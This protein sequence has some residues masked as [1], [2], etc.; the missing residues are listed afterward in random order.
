MQALLLLTCEQQSLEQLSGVTIQYVHLDDMGS[1]LAGIVQATCVCFGHESKW[2][3][4]HP[5]R[6][7]YSPGGKALCF[8]SLFIVSKPCHAGSVTCS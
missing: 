5:L 8:Y 6:S 3:W 1:V 7:Y 4:P 2:V